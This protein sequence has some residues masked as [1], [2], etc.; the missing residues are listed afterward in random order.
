MMLSDVIGVTAVVVADSISV[1]EAELVET[2]CGR[3]VLEME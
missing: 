1:S 3:D 2:A